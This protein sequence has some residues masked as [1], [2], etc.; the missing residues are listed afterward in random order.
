MTVPDTLLD[1]SL[2][3]V[4]L[5][6][7]LAEAEYAVRQVNAGHAALLWSVHEVLEEARRSPA[8]FVGPH[9]SA[10]NSEHVSFAERAAIADLAV[11]L[12]LSE[13][14]IRGHAHQATT[15]IERTPLVWQRLRLGEVPPANARLVAELVSTLPVERAELFV[16]FDEQVVDA[17][18]SLNPARFRTRARVIRERLL[19]STAIER[20]DAEGDRRRVFLEPALDGMCWLTAYLP[21][22]VGVVAI[23]ALDQHALDHA[24]ADDRTLDQLRADRLGELLTGVADGEAM[25]VRVG[26]VVPVL[27]LLDE[28]DA[29]AT[30]EGYG[31]ID[32]ATARRLTAKAPSFSRILTDPIEGTVL[33]IDKT[34]LYIPA[35][36]R[37]WLQVID[38]VCTFVGCGRLAVD[39][40]L[41]HTIDRQYGGITKVSN[42]SHLCRPHHRLKYKTGWR[43]RQLPDRT[44]EWTSPTGRVTRANPPPF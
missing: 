33:D 21:A 2:A 18:A 20:H 3:D 31:P 15:L 38:Q 22:E 1:A 35:D 5:E 34:T 26:L 14:T 17:A 6:F 7:G 23:A 12:S 10:E 43:I 28:D 24:A 30:L 19:A 4:R 44:I 37:R 41:D 11:R 42:L 13:N 25:P 36:M 9:A 8:V 40:D 27:S 16:S 32:P 39:S 29:P